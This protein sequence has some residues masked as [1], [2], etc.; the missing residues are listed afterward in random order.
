MGSRKAK[1]Q[2]KAAAASK[3]DI[4]DKDK[5]KTGERL[6]GLDPPIRYYDKDL[7]TKKVTETD[8][9]VKEANRL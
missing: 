7:F 5:P 2:A 8:T 3:K 6:P 4:T 1:S 9:T